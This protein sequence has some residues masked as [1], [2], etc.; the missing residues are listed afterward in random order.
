MRVW[1]NTTFRSLDL[2]GAPVAH[3][4]RDL[5]PLSEVIRRAV[6]ETTTVTLARCDPGTR[7]LPIDA[8]LLAADASSLTIGRPV[9]K[10]GQR[11]LA[12]GERLRIRFPLDGGTYIGA[13]SVLT[14][15][16]PEP[17]HVAYQLALPASLVHDDRRRAERV[18]IAF[19][20]PPVVEVL[21]AP[22]HRPVTTGALV[23][24]AMGG[25]RIRG[26]SDAHL[27]PGDRV[28]VRAKLSDD[29]RIHTLG[30]VV[31]ASRCPDGLTDIGVR[32]TTEIPHLDG[33]LRELVAQ[34]TPAPRPA[35]D[36]SAAD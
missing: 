26:G 29:M 24:L 17:G 31:H 18:A 1:T 8:P 7:P 11:S 6:A 22:T 19:Q 21:N 5:L 4:E 12:P 36:A 35:G 2:I 34:R 9:Y 15:F 14:R 30:V 10:P 16:E 28:V 13:T 25:A 33:Y 3:G 23:D 27:R 20:T 32:F